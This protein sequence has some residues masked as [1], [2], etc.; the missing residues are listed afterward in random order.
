MYSDET[1]QEHISRIR[2][3]LVIKPDSTILGIKEA[4][5]ASAKPLSLDKDYINK[6]VN[7]I[8]KERSERLDKYTVNKVLARF[9]DEV[10]ELKRRLWLIITGLDATEKDKIAAIKEIRNSSKDLFDK[11]FDAGVFKKQL[12]EVTSL[13]DLVREANKDKEK[14][15]EENRS[16]GDNGIV[17]EESE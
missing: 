3:L 4:L 13:I 14:E 5:G 11:M 9:Q 15:D 6:L 1:Q 12:G 16:K 10:E 17:G 2:R 7:M 8:R